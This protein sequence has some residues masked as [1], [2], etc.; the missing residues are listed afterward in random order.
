VVGL[1]L[2][3]LPS[4]VFAGVS[5]S[6]HDLTGGGDKLCQACHIPHNALGDK[7]WARTPSGTFGGVMDLCYTCHDG[8]VTSVGLTNVF[9]IT[10]E[11]HLNAGVDCSGAGACHDVHNQNPNPPGGPQTP[12]GG[13]FVVVTS[14]N[15]T[16]CETCHDATPFPGAEALG[17]HTAGIEH[18]TQSGVFTCN[19]CHSVHGA[20]NQT[21]SPYLTAP[22]LLGDNYPSTYWG[23]FCISCHSGTVPPSPMPGTGGVASSDPYDYSEADYSGSETKHPTIDWDPSW[24][25]AGCDKCHDPHDPTG[26]PSGYIL[27]TD[28]TDSGFCI[29]CHDGTTAPAVGAN[30]HFIQV[31]TDPTINNGLTPALPWA[32]EIDEDGV[33]GS[34]WAGATTNRM[35]CETCHSVHR[36]G[37]TG[38]DANYFLR[39]ENGATNQL[40]SAC[41]TD[42]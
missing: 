13:R 20:A 42:N 24:G 33:A 39:W 14:T 10:L 9:D 11:Q 16:Y 6:D 7:L 22:I 28:N 29:N 40:C 26:T 5:G 34:D 23:A 27:T 31:P 21:V 17:D 35:V 36:L 1:G 25:Y 37:N 15:G 18:Y 3:L 41:H 30:S 12:G 8:S 38:P 4:L 2:L 19:Q 32:N